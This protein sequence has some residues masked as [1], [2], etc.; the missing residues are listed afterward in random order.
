M[1][2]KFL[3]LSA[4][5]DNESWNLYKGTEYR[6]TF[7]KLE[8]ALLQNLHAGPA[9]VPPE[10][11]GW[12]IQR[13]I[14]NLY[15]M[16]I[17][18]EKFVYS[19][20]DYKKIINHGLIPPGSFWCEWIDGEHLSLNYRKDV[21]G[22][23]HLSSIWKGVLLSEH[24]LTKFDYWEKVSLSFGIE[25]YDLPY[26]VN[27]LDDL[28]TTCFNLET[29]GEKIIE[30]HLRSGDEIEDKFSIGDK[31]FPIWSDSNKKHENIIEEP[32]PEMSEF[33]AHGYISDIRN[34]FSLIKKLSD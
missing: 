24:N 31:I 29:K 30:I 10:K 8:V 5:A 22:R 21:T 33:K 14:Y 15:G 11:D 27:W 13:P 4:L 19:S 9:A 34:G 25:P 1:N 2:T 7:N 32:D 12:Y 23:W 18:A 16:G 26:F 20:L 6:W 28:K 17:G 3:P